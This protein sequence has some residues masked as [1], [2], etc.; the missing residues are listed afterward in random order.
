M[1]LEVS[2]FEKCINN[3][4]IKKDL[5]IGACHSFFNRVDSDKISLLFDIYYGKVAKELKKDDY[6]EALVGRYINLLEIMNRCMVFK[7][8]KSPY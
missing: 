1:K 7:Q 5:D 3:V 4:G 8:E 2:N 6:D